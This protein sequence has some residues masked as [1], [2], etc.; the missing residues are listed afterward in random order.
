[1][2]KETEKVWAE[3]CKIY[4]GILNEIQ[5]NKLYSVK[6]K[7][8]AS[9]DSR[10]RLS[11]SVK[12]I[13]SEIFTATKNHHEMNLKQRFVN[14]KIL[15]DYYDDGVSDCDVD[16]DLELDS[17][18]DEQASVAYSNFYIMYEAQLGRAG[19]FNV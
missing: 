17:V 8:Y 12:L 18:L 1:M 3:A 16:A 13:A 5:S 9:K 10:D 2:S 19:A 15:E 6:Q 7:N 14:F 11:Q 4:D